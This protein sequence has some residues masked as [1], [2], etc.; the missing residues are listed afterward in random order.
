MS[1]S[2]IVRFVDDSTIDFLFSKLSSSKSSAVEIMSFSNEINDGVRYT[3][4]NPVTYAIDSFSSMIEVLA[5]V[6][7][8]I[9]IGFAAFAALLLFSF[10][11]TSISYKRRDIGILRAVGAR[12]SDV[13]GIFFNEGGI[14][15]LI[16]FAIA[17]VG[18]VFAVY[19]F[20]NLFKDQLG[21]IIKVFN[22]GIRQFGLMLGI[23]LATALIASFIPVYRIARKKPVDAI[24][25]L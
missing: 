6:F 12:P 25:N 20:N 24:K 4:R 14:I 21:L 8:Y 2:D 16:S 19:Y 5:S 13:F 11:S 23:S 10:I 18:T 22:L 1:E 17:V 9:G 3:A 7:I 15:A